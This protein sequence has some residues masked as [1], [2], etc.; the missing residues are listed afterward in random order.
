MR[1]LGP[2]ELFKVVLGPGC[3]NWRLW[4]AWYPVKTLSGKRVWRKTVYKR[5]V[6]LVF[7]PGAI[8]EDRIQYGTV[9]D[10]FKNK[11]SDI[12]DFN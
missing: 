12:E 2:A 9:F 4:F 8:I 1:D 7:R 3:Y 10:T 11:Y 5:N 6:R